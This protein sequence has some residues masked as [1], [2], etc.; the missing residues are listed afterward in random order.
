MK[1][2]T[3]D[4]P[5]AGSVADVRDKLEAENPKLA[6]RPT[7]TCACCGT[8]YR[9]GEWKCCAPA[10]GMSSHNWS[11]AWHDGCPTADAADGPGKRKCPRHCRCPRKPDGNLIPAALVDLTPAEAKEAIDT[12]RHRTPSAARTS[13]LPVDPKDLAFCESEWPDEKPNR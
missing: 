4:L 13:S 7:L 12:L 11:L 10:G 9:R 8:R 6:N 5:L 3:L 2:D 1:Q